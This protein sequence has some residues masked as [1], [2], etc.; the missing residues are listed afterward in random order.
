ML[1]YLNND[2]VTWESKMTDKKVIKNTSYASQKKSL[3]MNNLCTILK[4]R[5]NQ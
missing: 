4:L 2:C 1:Q 5:K 3:G